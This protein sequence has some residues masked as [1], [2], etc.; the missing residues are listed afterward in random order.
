VNEEALAHW[1]LLRQK[2]ERGGER[3]EMEGKRKIIRRRSDRHY[4]YYQMIK[5][6]LL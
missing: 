3:Q 1:G 4:I 2:K 5:N 6:F